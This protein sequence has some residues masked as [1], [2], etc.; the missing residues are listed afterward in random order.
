VSACLAAHDKPASRLPKTPPTK[1]APA[2]WKTQ[3]SVGSVLMFEP[4]L[5]V[6]RHGYN[7]S[8]ASRNPLKKP[9]DAIPRIGKI[10]PPK[11][12]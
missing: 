6:H 4:R 11:R 7:M 9:L 10:S 8:V 2:P 5:D 3:I 1:R 12:E